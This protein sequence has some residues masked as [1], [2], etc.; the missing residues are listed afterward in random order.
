ML[1]PRCCE[2][3]PFGIGDFGERDIFAEARGEL[4]EP[5][6]GINFVEMRMG[7]RLKV[8]RTGGGRGHWI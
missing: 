4:F 1:K 6:P 3:V 2:G 5:G 7:A 8:L